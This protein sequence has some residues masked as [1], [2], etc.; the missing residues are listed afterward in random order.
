MFACFWAVFSRLPGTIVFLSTALCL[1]VGLRRLL[2]ISAGR[3]TT[4]NAPAWFLLL[5]LILDAGMVVA[6]LSVVGFLGLL[7]GLSV[8]TYLASYYGPTDSA[9]PIWLRTILGGMEELGFQFRVDIVSA[10]FAVVVLVV[11]SVCLFAYEL[12]NTTAG[13]VYTL[14]LKAVAC[15]S[16]CASNLLTF[17]VFT[18]IS[19]IIVLLIICQGRS[20][21]RLHAG[22]LYFIYSSVSGV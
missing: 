12:K 3:Q 6:L 4:P 22:F 16:F 1:V 21:K 9:D 20:A 10:I 14:L 13:I 18:E 5:V 19:S 17:T 8:S 2:F 15:C 7:R 11:L